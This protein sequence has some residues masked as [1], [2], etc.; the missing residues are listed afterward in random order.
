MEPSAFIKYLQDKPIP[1]RM[2][3]RDIHGSLTEYERLEML[4]FTIHDLK[5]IVVSLPVPDNG[6]LNVD[7]LP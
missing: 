2:S 4:E 6:D 1:I 3:V 7:R 5:K